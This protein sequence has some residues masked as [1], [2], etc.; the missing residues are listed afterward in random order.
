MKKRLEKVDLIC[1]CFLSIVRYSV[2][3]I[4]QRFRSEDK[5]Y[6]FK[7]HCPQNFCGAPQTLSGVYVGDLLFSS[8]ESNFFFR[9]CLLYLKRKVSAKVKLTT[10]LQSE[11]TKVI[12]FANVNLTQTYARLA[13]I[14]L[15]FISP[16]RQNG[17]PSQKALYIIVEDFVSPMLS[18]QQFFRG[19]CSSDSEMWNSRMTQNR[20]QKP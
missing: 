12:H 13:L 14:S 20:H 5:I 17:Q 8:C 2:I 4:C 9:G 10:V 19:L 1:K 16:E 6:D 11:T 15:T 18:S 7:V 3:K